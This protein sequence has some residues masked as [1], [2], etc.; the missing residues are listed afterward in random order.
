MLIVVRH[1]WLVL[2]SLVL[3]GCGQP[4][5]IDSNGTVR[6]TRTVTQGPAHPTSAATMTTTDAPLSPATAPPTM[7]T[8]VAGG[9]ETEAAASGGTPIV[10]T[11]PAIDVVVVPQPQPALNNHD[12]WRAQQIDRQVFEQAQ[13]Y[14]ARRPAP[15]QWYDPLTGQS[16]EVGTLIGDFTVQARFIL[17]GTNSPALEVPYRINADYGLTSIS[18][19]VRSRMQ[20]AG[21]TESVEAYVVQ[22]E[23]TVPK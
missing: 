19:A 23:D 5:Q 7:P 12:R 4:L 18:E 21:Y 22:T 11:A 16:L 9:A 20:A 2:L 8:P 13:V 1:R 15:L 6:P 14:V 3:V 10:P 17:R